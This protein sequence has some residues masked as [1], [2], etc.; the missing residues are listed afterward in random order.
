MQ[1]RTHRRR[2]LLTIVSFVMFSCGVANAQYLSGPAYQ[3]PIID[4][5]GP[6]LTGAAMQSYIN[7]ADKKTRGNQPPTSTRPQAAL[8]VSDNAEISRQVKRAFRDQLLSGNPG[9]KGAVDQ[10]LRTDWLTG[11]RDEIARPNGLQHGNLADVI[12]AYLI[13]GWA[14][15]HKREVIS[16]QSIRAVR[17]QLRQTMPS[18]Q[19]L[20]RQSD[21]ER[22]RMAEELMYSTVLMMANRIEIARTKNAQLAD[23]ASRH[24]RHVVK[25]G[26]MV[27]LSK[28]A[29]TDAGFSSLAPE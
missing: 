23:Q 20:A 27:D 19:L 12:T 10:V 22:Q 15:V 9:Q 16:P 3:A 14:I 18:N 5:T 24:Y 17:D 8:R 7:T 1:T 28:L 29:L 26:M 2:L 21:V 25:S 6:M 11:Y 13:A 4:M